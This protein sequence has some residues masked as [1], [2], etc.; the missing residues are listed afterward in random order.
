MKK[1]KHHYFYDRPI[2]PDREQRY[3]NE[4]LTQFREEPANEK[5]MEKIWNALQ[6][7]KSIGN[8]RIPFKLSLRK[9][10]Y[11]QYP[12]LIEIILDTKI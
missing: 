12:T 10:P 3:I 9:D 5:L 4:V 8:I 1:S 7:E 2:F 6:Y 11:N